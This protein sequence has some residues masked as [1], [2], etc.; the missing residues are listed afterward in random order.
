GTLA[1]FLLVLN[2]YGLI[3][4]APPT[5]DLSV[6]V[7]LAITSFVVVHVNAIR[8]CHI[9]G[10]IKGYFKPYPLMLP[11]N[12]MERI[13]FPVSLAL[14]LFGNMLAATLLIDLMYSGLG[15]IS[16]FA[17]LGMPILAHGF[18]DVFDGTIQMIVFT[19]LTMVN[20]KI[21]ADH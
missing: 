21:I 6:A 4:L 2:F 16:W 1:I 18:F 14:R 8:R 7:A 19:M 11:L 12:L 10:Y 9:G 15:H 3:G 13:I 20:I 5:Q 17:Q